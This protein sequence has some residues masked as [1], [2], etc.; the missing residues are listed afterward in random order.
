MQ[1]KRENSKK[2][3]KENPELRDEIEAKVRAALAPAPA[4]NEQKEDSGDENTN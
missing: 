4:E 1:K 3:L 2:Y